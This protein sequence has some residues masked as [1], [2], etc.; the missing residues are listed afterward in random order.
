MTAVDGIA[1]TTPRDG[2]MLTLAAYTPNR[3]GCTAPAVC[4]RAALPG[5]S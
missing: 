2:T 3:E 4:S 5:K 1:V